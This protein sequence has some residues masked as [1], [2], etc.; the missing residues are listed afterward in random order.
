M[1]QCRRD[2]NN[3]HELLSALAKATSFLDPSNPILSSDTNPSKHA[4]N[5]AILRV[6]NYT[7][8]TI[9]APIH[10]DSSIPCAAARLWLETFHNL[11]RP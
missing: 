2:Q 4:A 3:S 7:R 6:S 9:D 10:P 5:L 11:P 8:E 1:P